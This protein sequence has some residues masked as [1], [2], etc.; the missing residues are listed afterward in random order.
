MGTT[1]KP[2]D[3]ELS[4]NATMYVDGSKV[5]ITIPDRG[6][7]SPDWFALRVRPASNCTNDTGILSNWTNGLGQRNHTYGCPNTV[8]SVNGQPGVSTVV[9][10]A[11]KRA[12][13]PVVFDLVYGNME[14]LYHKALSLEGP[15]IPL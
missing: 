4:S 1:V 3:I 5:R 14:R 13:G 6:L 9:W 7:Y 10:T 15:P 8:V 12:C 11:G 2:G